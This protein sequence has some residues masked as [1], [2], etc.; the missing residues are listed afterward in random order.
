MTNLAKKSISKEILPIAVM[1]YGLLQVI[2]TTQAAQA[3]WGMAVGL[4]VFGLGAY[5]W[6]HFR[7]K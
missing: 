7:V 6:V 1:G 2:L 4:A 3:Q 5:L